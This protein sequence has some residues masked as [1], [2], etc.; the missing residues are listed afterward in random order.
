MEKYYQILGIP[1]NSSKEVIKKAY[2]EKI[3]ALHPDKIH[4]TPLEAT[5]TFFTAEINEAYNKLMSQ[6]DEKKTLSNQENQNKPK[7]SDSKQKDFIE[8]EIYIENFGLLRY[9]LSNNIN[10]ILNSITRR[11]GVIIP[12][13]AKEIPWT[14]NTRL[15]ENVKKSMNKNNM[16]YSTTMYY[17]DSYIQIIIN[18]RIGNTW[19]V[20]GYDDTPIGV[21]STKIYYN[22][23]NKNT[24]KSESSGV[25]KKLIL[26]SIAI[27]AFIFIYN[28]SNNALTAGNRPFSLAN[29]STQ[30]YAVVVSC[31]WL[32][33]RSSP[34]SVNSSNIIGAVQVN[35]RVEILENTNNGWARIK[36]SLDKTGYVHGNYLSR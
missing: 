9:T 30:V 8:E 31:D 15:S 28:Y 19:Y 24:K 26:I 20:T 3:K 5:A 6:A 36:Y 10:I 1:N 11:S 16:N 4:G 13:S 32:N 7:Q 29:K 21:T 35:T 18:K 33:V 2:Y 14:K 23:T 25:F 27:I 12:D 34:S 17:S 22:K